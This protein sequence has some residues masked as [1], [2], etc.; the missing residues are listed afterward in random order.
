MKIKTIELHNYRA[1]YG[2][3]VLPV[4]GKNLLIYGEN[5][6][7]KSSLFKAIERFFESV[8]T[9]NL[10]P[11]ANIFAD[12]PSKPSVQIAM[13]NGEIFRFETGIIPQPVPFLSEN[14]KQRPFFSYR[15]LL[16]LHVAAKEGEDVNLLG[17]LVRDILHN[18][19][20]PITSKTLGE[21]WQEL[22]SL[23]VGDKDLRTVDSKKILDN[24]QNID[25]G[26]RQ[27]L[28]ET[29]KKAN[30]YLK[31]Y[32]DYLLEIR[33][34]WEESINFQRS[35]RKA[36]GSVYLGARHYGKEVPGILGNFLNEARLS[37]VAL[38]IYLASLKTTPKPAD[39]AILFMD[40]I[41]VGLDMGNRIPLL[42]LISK[43]FSDYQIF[44][45]TYDRH[46][47]E[48]AKS[49]LENDWLSVEMYAGVKKVVA[50]GSFEYPIISS[51]SDGHYEKAEKYANRKKSEDGK[52]I[53][54]A[55]AGNYLRK[56]AERLLKDIL[57]VGKYRYKQ[58]D[59]GEISLRDQLQELWDSFLAQVEGWDSPLLKKYTS[60]VKSV[61]NPL[62]HDNLSKPVYRRELEAA[63]EFIDELRTLSMRK[64]LSKGDKVYLSVQTDTDTQRKFHVQSEEDIYAYD[65]KNV[66]TW[67]NLDKA[68]FS[69]ESYEESGKIDNLKTKE[70][71]RTLS[72]LYNR[73]YHDT[74]KVK[75]ASEGKE[76]LLE[77]VNETGVPLYFIRQ[78]IQA[79]H[80]IQIEGKGDYYLLKDN[81]L[82]KF[83][84]EDTRYYLGY[85][86]NKPL[87]IPNTHGIP[88]GNGLPNIR[89]KNLR[90]IELKDK[91]DGGRI[92]L[93]I[94]GVRRH[95]PDP[96][97][98]KDIRG[99]DPKSSE[100][101][102]LLEKEYWAIP[103]GKLLERKIN[104]YSKSNIM[105]QT[106]FNKFHEKIRLTFD[107]SSSLREKRD[108][109]VE[110]IRKDIKAKFDSLLIK[111][112]T[113]EVFNQ[114]SYYIGTG[115]R[116]LPN[117]DYDIDIGL[118][119]HFKRDDHKPVEV[120][121][122]IYDALSKN[123][124]RKVEFKTPCIR[125]Q[126]TKKGDDL[127]HVDIVAYCEETGILGD[128]NLYIAKGKPGSSTE[129]KK[130]EISQPHELKERLDK[131]YS[132]EDAQQFKRVI[133]YLKRWKDFH[134]S[135]SGYARP[136]GIA[137]TA[138][139]YNK[140][141]PAAEYDSKTGRYTLY[142]DV[143]ALRDIVKYI[144]A[145][146]GL[147]TERISIKLPVEP[148]NDLFEK[149]GNQQHKDLKTKLEKL[150]NN[151]DEAM[152][153][154]RNGDVA[155]ARKLMVKEFGSDFPS[156]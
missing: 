34:N 73:A 76:I 27:V 7:G 11:E 21:E 24:V 74:Q 64:V 128:K 13:D 106:D 82:R 79:G 42:R 156:S 88:I 135:S 49:I 152:R 9:P 75:N 86:E 36:G 102:Y 5:G 71:G 80:L 57:L 35:T 112:P 58:N 96:E 18:H 99:T 81:Q 148:G 44:L 83:P 139:A 124:N 154:E 62:S 51:P 31:E 63:F 146:F 40:D 26:I 111:T 92:F 155:G 23:E 107:E 38:C 119:F 100:I 43:E 60:V 2:S 140:F 29:E 14:S 91:A 16:R 6:S 93:E 46:W 108:L 122:W 145:E 142:N 17:P 120:K 147:F 121:Q 4:G 65:V 95:I 53:D 28:T 116:P 10:D 94:E 113:F 129:N 54:Y 45:T 70:E 131:R 141:R 48:L 15:N 41:F 144:I 20:N 114:G 68:H 30:E 47:F 39:P 136:T 127:F 66:F 32:F 101:T 69:C 61:L 55:V 125:V 25:S 8:R 78:N 50:G 37:A 97:T 137:I 123:P 132:G 85:W 150:R 77:Y 126:Y 153:L 115:I 104:I 90:V 134:F 117:E 143:Q 151:L 130:W 12:E 67:S 33:L 19:L 72:T 98:F 149:M 1:F 109:L 133:R 84:D 22:L 56:E 105:A 59:K 110:E 118:Q 138:C 87:V 3:H 103:E 89:D 52:N